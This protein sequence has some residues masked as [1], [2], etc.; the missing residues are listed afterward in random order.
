MT[1]QCL[2]IS[3]HKNLLSHETFYKTSGLSISFSAQTLS[4]VFQFVWHVTHATVFFGWSSGFIVSVKLNCLER[5]EKLFC[6]VMSFILVGGLICHSC[7][8]LCTH[9]HVTLGLKTSDWEASQ[10]IFLL[11]KCLQ[12]SISPAITAFTFLRKQ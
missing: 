12:N 9:S 1:P 7:K 10:M 4:S 3:I 11:E 5:W 6:F 2:L 8:F